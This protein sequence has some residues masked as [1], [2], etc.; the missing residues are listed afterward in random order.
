MAHA[1]EERA[2]PRGTIA[3]CQG[4]PLAAASIPVDAPTVWC[5][6]AL[7]N[8]DRTGERDPRLGQG[9]V[10]QLFDFWQITHAKHS[11]HGA[12]DAPLRIEVLSEA[13]F[14]AGGVGDAF[15]T[16]GAFGGSVNPQDFGVALDLLCRCSCLG[17]SHVWQLCQDLLHHNP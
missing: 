2:E 1:H 8:H 15:A 11:R 14:R 12:D 9:T 7:A 16:G 4:T 10:V 5:V 6:A 17:P 3:T 13:H